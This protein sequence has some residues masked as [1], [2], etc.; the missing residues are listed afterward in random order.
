MVTAPAVSDS[1]ARHVLAR[2]SDFFTDEGTPW[3]RRLWDIGSVLAL[4]ELWEAGSW[5]A[6]GVLSP[7][8]CDW[9]SNELNALIGPDRGLGDRDLR[10]ELTGLLKNSLP[11]PSP[12]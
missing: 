2:M 4:E 1:Y 6:Q 5:Q 8:A 12:A 10:K 9:Q 3:A 7:T 11:D